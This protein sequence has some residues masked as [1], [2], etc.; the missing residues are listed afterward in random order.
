MRA[1]SGIRLAAVAAA[2]LLLAGCAGLPTTGAPQP[3]LAIGDDAEAPPF[4]LTAEKP[5]AG[6]GPEEIVAGFLEASMTPV[7]DWEIAQEYLTEDF[8]S[9]WKPD[10]GVAIDTSVE[11]RRIAST[12]QADDEEATSAEVRVELDQIASVDADGAYSALPAPGKSTY[13]LTRTEG[14]EWRIADAPDGIVLDTDTFGQ[15]YQKYALKYFDTS[16]SHLVPDV[17]WFPR[18]AAMATSI[19]RALISGQPSGWL[20]PAVRSAFT[21]DVSLAG[22]AVVV[23]ASVA[24]VSLSRAALTAS[25]TVL[26]RMRTQLEASLV[27]A[28]VSEVRFTVDGA[29]LDADTVPVDDTI[30]DPGVLVLNGEMFG[31]TT[32]GSALTPVDGLT[33]QFDR[34]ADPIRSLDISA[35]ATLAAMQLRDGRV[36]AVTAGDSVGLDER[37]G[38]IEPSLDPFGFT[39]TVPSDHPDRLKAVSAQVEQHDIA[40]AWPSADSISHLRVSADGARVAAVVTTGGQRRV[41]VFAVLRGEDSKPTELGEIPL[42]VGHVNGPV[43]GLAWIGSDALAVLSGTPEPTLTTY[44]VGGPSSSSPAPDGSVAI[45]GARTPTGLRVLTADGTVYAQRGS[46]WQ[47]AVQDVLVLGTRAGY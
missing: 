36:F 11:S 46:S 44:A 8:K 1:H 6:D 40:R 23:E 47:I 17:R 31:T 9:T 41:V 38:L 35:T 20:A 33:D 26:A 21:E 19:S 42:E 12:V 39:W 27:E 5:R 32:S 14:G 18:R 3:G 34:I 16:W 24:S 28:G 10:M 2:A 4:T 37:S 15:V 29:L 30:V 43:Q 7:G 13:R 22:D 45:A 25:P